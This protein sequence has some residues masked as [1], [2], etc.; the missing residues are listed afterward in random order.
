MIEKAR[1]N[2]VVARSVA[3]GSTNPVKVRAVAAAFRTVWPEVDWNV[4][5]VSVDSGVRSQP[6]SDEES[7]AG[8]RQRAHRARAALDADF[9]AGLEGGLQHT[10]GWWLDCGW[11]VI[12]D[13]EDREGLGSTLKM[14]VPPPMMERIRAGDELGDAVDQMFGVSNAKQAGG[15]F[16]LMTHGAVDRTT[17]FVHGVI[18]ALVRFLHPE[19]FGGVPGDWGGEPATARGGQLQDR[20]GP[21]PDR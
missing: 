16:G 14:A 9:G 10:A 6:M 15:H 7:V 5:G 21:A 20:A 13:R 1:G 4:R 18:A 3:V 12:V 11:V 8:A 2:A 17:S 19:L